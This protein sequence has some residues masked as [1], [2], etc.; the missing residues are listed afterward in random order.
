MTAAIVTGF[1]QSVTMPR[2]PP[3]S[4]PVARGHESGPVIRMRRTFLAA[5]PLERL[6]RGGS[7]GVGNR[8]A[9]ESGAIETIHE[10]ARLTIRHREEAHHD[11]TCPGDLER[12]AQ[13]EDSF[14]DRNLPRARI[15]PGQHHEAG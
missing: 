2:P 15:A 3:F 14:A 9:V 12:P 8:P 1:L 7:R 11:R 4:V 10:E 5:Q 6:E 13:P